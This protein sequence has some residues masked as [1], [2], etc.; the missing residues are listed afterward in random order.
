MSAGTDAQRATLRDESAQ[1]RY[2]RVSTRMWNDR[3]VRALGH[4][5]PHPMYLFM[6]LLTN[7]A[8]TGVPG[9]FRARDLSLAMELGWPIE[10][11]RSAFASLEAQGM[12]Q[13]DWQAGLVW[14]PNAVKHEPPGSPNVVVSWGKLVRNDMPECGL[15]LRALVRIREQIE[16]LFERPASFL[17]AFD[18]GIPK[19]FLQGLA[20]GF[21][22]ALPEGFR[23]ENPKPSRK[24]YPNQDQDQDHRA[25]PRPPL[26]SKSTRA[27]SA[28]PVPALGARAAQQEAAAADN[29]DAELPPGF[30]RTADGRTIP[31]KPI[32]APPRTK[33]ERE[34]LFAARREAA[35]RGGVEVAP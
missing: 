28:A 18:K 11:F 30:I 23:K 1:S 31:E 7:P 5:E 10:G 26:C 34:A 8:T 22:E 20:E 16:S 35:R 29:A 17:A 25:A 6:Y 24:A 27:A 19:A 9:L 32:R 2:R 12:V 4:P 14:L 15:L 3:R 33:A 21:P 13:A